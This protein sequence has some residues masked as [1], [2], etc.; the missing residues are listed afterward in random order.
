MRLLA[1]PRGRS[2]AEIGPGETVRSVERA[3][4]WRLT[5]RGKRARRYSLQASLATLN[6]PF[7]PCAVTLQGRPLPRRAWS[8]DRPTRV[9]RTKVT[10]R[11]G[12]VVAR[13]TCVR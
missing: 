9:L 6:R 2:R 12:A 11:S 13:R 4:A 8:Y 5:V 3:G 10:L 1:F 7:R